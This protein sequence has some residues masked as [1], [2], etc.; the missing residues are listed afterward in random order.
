MSYKYD[1]KDEKYSDDGK[2]YCNYDN[3]NDKKGSPDFAKIE[4]TSID[5]TSDKQL[6]SDPINLKIN[7]ELDRYQQCNI[8]NTIISPFYCKFIR[9]VVCAHWLVK[10]LVDSTENRIIKILG[11]TSVEDYPDGESDMSFYIEK[12]DVND[13]PPSTLANSGLLIAAFVVDGEEIACVNI[14]VNVFFDKS[15]GQLMRQFLN[16]LE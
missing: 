3:D 16:P 10:F 1:E 5:I 12:I 14:V 9:D 15:S 7:F 13:I 8:H 2:D 11:S 6:I 4:I